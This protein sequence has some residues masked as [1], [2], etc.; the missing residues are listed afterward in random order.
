MKMIDLVNASPAL[1]K[2]A[3][4]DL[5]VRVAY[6][7]SRVIKKLDEHLN[8]HDQRFSELLTK[9]CEQKDEHWYPKSKEDGERFQS[10]RAELLDLTIDLGEFKKVTIPADEKIAISAVDVMSLENFIEIKFAEGEEGN[11]RC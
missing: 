10:E 1:R 2:L 8:F 5:S 11:T 4:Q 3:T 6:E 9:Y 7:I